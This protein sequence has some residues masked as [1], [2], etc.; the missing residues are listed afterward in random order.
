MTDDRMALV[1]LLETSGNGDFPRAWRRR[2]RGTNA[3]PVGS[4]TERLSRLTVRRPARGIEPADPKLRQGSYFFPF[5]EPRKTPEKA[6]VTM[7]QEVWIGGVS[8]RRV[9]E[10]VQSMR[11]FTRDSMLDD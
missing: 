9:D 3:A 8:T 5:L 1:E 2:Y 10:L 6:L 11:L 4:I 7:I